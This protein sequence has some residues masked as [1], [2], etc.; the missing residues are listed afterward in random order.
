MEMQFDKTVCRCL[1]HAVREVQNQEQTQEVKLPDSYPDIGSVISA[2]GQVILRGKEWRSDGMSASG[3][4]MTWI[5]YAPEDG[6]QP[7]CIE[8]WLPFQMKWD[9]P[10]TEREGSII[11]QP[12]LR[13]V[14]A[15]TISARKMMVRANVAIMGEAMEPWEVTSYQPPQETD[16]VELLRQTYPVRLHIQSGEKAFLLDEELT[17]PASCPAADK[18]LRYDVMPILQEQKVMAGRVVFRGLAN[19]HVLYQCESGDMESWDFEVPF[20]QYADLDGETDSD[21]RAHIVMAVTSM[22]LDLTEEGPIRLKCGLVGQYV[23]SEL[24]MLEIAE[25]AY[26]PDRNVSPWMQMLTVPAILEKRQESVLAEQSVPAEQGRV[27]DVSYLPDFPRSSRMGDQIQ[28]ELPGVFQILY[29][30]GAGMIQSAVL[31]SSSTWEMPVDTQAD[32]QMSIIQSGRPQG[33]INGGSMTARSGM[34]LHVLTSSE[35]SIPMLM[36]MDVGE[37]VTPDP[38]RPSLILRRAD[39]QG[40]W[41]L[42]KA[43]G[44]TMEAIRRA[45]GITGDPAEGQMLLIPVP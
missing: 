26:S 24:K 19:V 32:V 28:A 6:T 30:D 9:F 27:L 33:N 21:A 20:S 7:Q 43:C 39:G 41:N 15:R 2:W 16:H 22:E 10:E 37:P 29:R 38:M 1:K 42:A 23:L 13:S 45:N 25:D 11:L 35:Q 8:T 12:L 34:E 5:L 36:G 44:S 17:L 14:D 4:V 40:L 31:R 3:G 18:I